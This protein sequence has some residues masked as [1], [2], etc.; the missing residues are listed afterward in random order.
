MVMQSFKT[1]FNDTRAECLKQVERYIGRE[2]TWVFDGDEIFDVLPEAPGLYLCGFN[3]TGYIH[4]LNGTDKV[5]V[6]VD[7]RRSCVVRILSH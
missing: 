2:P 6:Y 3:E 4:R 7:S 5:C 1:P